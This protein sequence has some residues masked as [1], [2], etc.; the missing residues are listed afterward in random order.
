MPGIVSAGHGKLDYD[1]YVSLLHRYGLKGP[2]LLHG[3]SEAQVPECVAFLR[4]KIGIDDAL[5]HCA[6]LRKLMNAQGLT[7]HRRPPPCP[8]CLHFPP[9]P[10]KCAPEDKSP[11]ILPAMGMLAQTI[12]IQG[13]VGAGRAAAGDR[14]RVRGREHRALAHHRAR[15]RTGPGK[16]ATYES[17]MVPI[18][19]TRKR[20]NVRF[21]IVAMIFLV[22]DVEI[23]FFYP[24][25]TI[26]APAD[27]RQ[28]RRTEH[29]ADAAGRD[30]HLRRHPAARVPL[31][32]GQGR[33]PVGLRPFGLRISIWIARESGRFVRTSRLQI[34][35]ATRTRISNDR[36]QSSC[37]DYPNAFPDNVL[38][39]QL[40]RVVNWARRSL[41]VADAVR[42]GVLRDRADGDGVVAL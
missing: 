40:K 15:R 23:V 24:W 33:L 41:A 3:L 32:L 38:T 18:G 22:F 8:A 28:R 16:E 35:D 36:W 2:L 11:M 1:R 19:D 17:G 13:F 39:T 5:H 37:S 12:E 29:C 4:N 26:F 14:D 34:A 30:G 21:Y 20:F 31:R 42:D 6:R 10:L 25:A 27:G 9:T 7:R